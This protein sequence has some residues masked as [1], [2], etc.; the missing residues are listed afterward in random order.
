M[1]RRQFLEWNRH[2]TIC[3]MTHRYISLSEMLMQKLAGSRK[4]LRHALSSAACKRPMKKNL[5]PQITIRNNRACPRKARANH[6]SDGALVRSV[7]NTCTPPEPDLFQHRLDLRIGHEQFPD[8]PGAIVFDHHCDGRL[9]QSHE[10]WRDPVFVQVDCIAR[11]INS[12][13][14][15]SE[16]AINML[17]RRH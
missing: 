7:H 15:V 8:Q 2:G 9:V 6:E 10:D 17:Q 14:L 11:T 1:P 12:P 16:I 4:L 13:D 3:K 5:R